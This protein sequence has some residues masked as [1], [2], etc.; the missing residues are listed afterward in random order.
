MTTGQRIEALS[1][2]G[3]K[4]SRINIQSDRI[5]VTVVNLALRDV[6]PHEEK[7]S[8]TAVQHGS[9]KTTNSS[10]REISQKGSALMSYEPLFSLEI[11]T[12]GLGST[13]HKPSKTTTLHKV[14]V[15]TKTGQKAKKQPF[16]TTTLTEKAKK[17]NHPKPPHP[18]KMNNSTVVQTDVLPDSPFT[19]NSAQWSAA[20]TIRG[21]SAFRGGSLRDNR[22]IFWHAK[23]S[24]RCP[25]KTIIFSSKNPASKTM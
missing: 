5:R 4:C 6:A 15:T 25:L 16:K 3:A 10:Q 21:T 1:S 14:D 12:H 8:K 22:L 17:K 18:P 24:K 13:K 23:D 19:G 2:R 11:E 7:Q 9:F 20:K